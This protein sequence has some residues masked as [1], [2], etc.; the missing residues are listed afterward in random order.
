MLYSDIH[1]GTSCSLFYKIPTTCGLHRGRWQASDRIANV[2]TFI[3]PISKRWGKT[4]G[5]P[6][7]CVVCEHRHWHERIL[8]DGTSGKSTAGVAFFAPFV[9]AVGDILKHF[10]RSPSPNGCSDLIRV[11]WFLQMRIFTQ[12]CQKISRLHCIHNTSHINC[13]LQADTPFHAP[14]MAPNMRILRLVHKRTNQRA[15]FQARSLLYYPLLR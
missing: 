13:N 15:K 11:I 9:F 12:C 7:V 5:G 6:M 3:L 14:R 2:P 1:I 4:I 10:D 8:F